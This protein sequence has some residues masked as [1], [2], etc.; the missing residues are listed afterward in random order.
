MGSQDVRNKGFGP[1]RSRGNWPVLSLIDLAEVKRNWYWFL[2]FGIALVALGV[3]AI[4]SSVYTTLFT[5]IFLGSLLTIG[6]IAKIVY[7]FWLNEWGGVL[8]SLLGGIFYTV[9]GLYIAL[10]P[11]PSAIAVTLL[12]AILF[13]VEGL[14]KLVGSAF[15]RF[16][17]WGWVAFSGVISIVL[18]ALILAQW[19][20]SG[21]WVLG[22]FL[23]IDL[24]FYG[25]SWVFLA[26]AAH[27]IGNK[28]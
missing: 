23:G 16:E 24:I 3:F 28:G 17:G 10:H 13:L 14:F 5:L 18:G 20:S 19:P 7:S 2:I 11:A 25:W 12:M 22:L 8:L 27:R 1:D 9:V 6:G 15:T 26:M 4:G 21:L